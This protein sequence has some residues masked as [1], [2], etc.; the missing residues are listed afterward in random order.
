MTKLTRSQVTGLVCPA[1]NILRAIELEL[2]GCSCVY[3]DKVRPAVDN[4][5]QLII[6]SGEKNETE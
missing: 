1:L 3:R 2:T 4:L 5:L 6:L